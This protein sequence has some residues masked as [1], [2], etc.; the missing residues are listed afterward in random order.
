[1]RY[2]LVESLLASRVM[3]DSILIHGNHEVQLLLQTLMFA[4]KNVPAGG[5]MGGILEPFTRMA[6]P[7]HFLFLVTSCFGADEL[8]N[9]IQVE[10]CS[11]LPRCIF[12]LHTGCLFKMNFG[13]RGLFSKIKCLSWAW[14]HTPLILALGRLRQKDNEFKASLGCIV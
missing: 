11:N 12:I 2:P 10:H 6:A 1:M 7:W 5:F 3:F 13:Q 4:C 8:S 9:P 14:W